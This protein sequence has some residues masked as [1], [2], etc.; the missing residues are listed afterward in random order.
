MKCTKCDKIPC[1]E[2]G[3][4]N[5]EE[6]PG[7]LWIKFDR[8]ET[9]PLHNKILAINKIGD[10]EVCYLTREGSNEYPSWYTYQSR[11]RFEPTHWMPL[12]KYPEYE[13]G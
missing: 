12:P 5:C 8:N 3:T 6:K 4:C 2:C 11:Q 9:P 7:S 13:D 1:L 10:M